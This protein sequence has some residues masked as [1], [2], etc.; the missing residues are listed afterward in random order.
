MMYCG[1][2]VK[3]VMIQNIDKVTQRGDKLEDLGERAG[4]GEGGEG[5]R[6]REDSEEGRET[7]AG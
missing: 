1:M 2:Q 3:G 5:Q 6:G 4:R 7:E